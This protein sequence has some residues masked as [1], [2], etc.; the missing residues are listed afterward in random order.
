MIF[1]FI[2][3]VLGLNACAVV[4]SPLVFIDSDWARITV[5]I[6]GLILMLEGII[7]AANWLLERK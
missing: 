6:A 4:A 7:Q 2:K 3:F 1:A 5:G